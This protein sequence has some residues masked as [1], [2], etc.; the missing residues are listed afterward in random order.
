MNSIKNA[1]NK[2]F[3]LFSNPTELVYLPTYQIQMILLKQEVDNKFFE[4]LISINNPII[5]MFVF[6][7]THEHDQNHIGCYESSKYQ[8]SIYFCF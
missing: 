6:M 8:S 5:N 4:Q 2:T 3:N 1:C 7:D